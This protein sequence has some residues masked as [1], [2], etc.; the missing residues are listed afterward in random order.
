MVFLYSISMSSKETIT[1]PSDIQSCHGII[2]ELV[3][4]VRK[5]GRDYERLRSMYENLVQHRYGRKSERLEDI[6]PSLLLPF[7]QDYLKEHEKQPEEKK[8]AP[9]EEFEEITYTRKKGHGRKAI[10]DSLERERR[11]Y[12][13]EDAEKTCQCCG[14]QL[15]VFGE[16]TSEQ[17]DFIPA[18]LYVIEHVQLKYACKQCQENVKVAEKPRQP[19]E[20][21]IAASGLI[22]HVAVSRFADHLPYYRQEGIFKRHNIDISRSSMCDWMIS[23][24]ELLQPLLIEMTRR[25]LLSKVIGTDDTTVQLQDEMKS[26]KTRTARLWVYYGNKDHPYN[27]YDFTPTRERA[28]PERFLQTYQE[29]YIQADAYPGYDGIFND[30]ERNVKELLCWAHARR[31]FHEAQKSDPELSHSAI[32][33]IKL[34]YQ[35]EKDIKDKPSETKYSVRQKRSV[36]ILNNIKQWLGSITL[37]RALPQSPIRGAINYALNGW[38][39]LC[40]YTEDGDFDIDNNATERLMRPIAIG[41]KNWLFIGS[42][43]GGQTAA[44]LFSVVQSAKRHNLNVFTYLKDVIER[45]SDHPANQIHKLLPDQWKPATE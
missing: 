17:L 36:P 33:M 30:K 31:K 19:I 18:R 23:L 1:L 35:V 44:T 7:V 5:Q 38:D 45:I 39:A 4:T 41:R 2:Q 11:V 29:G 24:A 34:L 20:K 21:G 22:T 8:P 12:D 3:E 13:I 6:A 43:K 15:Q 10:P 27:V 28:G 42:V 14:D 16:Q 26:K 25:V 32:A 37:E 40:R 9:K